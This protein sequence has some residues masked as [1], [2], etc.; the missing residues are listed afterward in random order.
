MNKKYI[1]LFKELAQATA[2]SAEMV[3]DYDRQKDDAKGLEAATVLRDDFQNLKEALEVEGYKLSKIDAA[4][5]LVAAMIQVNQLSD[6]IANLKTAMAGFQD[7][8][9][10]KLQSIVDAS[11]DEEAA[12]LADEKFVIVTETNI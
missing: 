8:V 10:P 1:T 4:R 6:K 7:D 2:A 11:S 12:Q 3:M 9:V 5:L